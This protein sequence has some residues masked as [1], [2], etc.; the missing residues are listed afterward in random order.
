MLLLR[1]AIL[2]F[3][4]GDKMGVITKRIKE[5][6]PVVKELDALAERCHS[7]YKEVLNKANEVEKCFLLLAPFS[8]RRDVVVVPKNARSIKA[9]EYVVGRRR[10]YRVYVYDDGY[11]SDQILLVGLDFVEAIKADGNKIAR[12]VREKIADDFRELVSITKE[13]TWEFEVT[14]EGEF[15]VLVQDLDRLYVTVPEFATYSRIRITSGALGAR[16]VCFEEPKDEPKSMSEILAA[17]RAVFL[18]QVYILDEYYGLI[19]EML[20]ELHE[21][22]SAACKSGEKVLKR[23]REVVAPYALARACA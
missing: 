17:R 12:V 21:K 13:F 20:K 8:P 5:L 11:T 2:D 19:K 10:M 1:L 22:L 7:L 23:M 15:E 9:V 3:S 18:S 14:R 4:L 6:T 16:K